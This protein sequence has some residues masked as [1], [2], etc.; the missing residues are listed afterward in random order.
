[1]FQ[2]FT[3]ALPDTT[4]SGDAAA[5]AQRVLAAIR[6]GH[7]YSTIDGLGGATAMSFT[8]V[9]GTVT[10]V[11]GDALPLDGP[12][13]LRVDVQGPDT[14][15]IDVLKDGRLLQTSTGTEL[16]LVVDATAAVYRVEVALPGSPGDPPVP[17]VVSNPIYVGREA[18]ATVLS[19][20]HADASGFAVQY[21]DGPASDWTIE[22]SPASLGALDVVPA[23]GGRQLSLRYGLGGTSAAGPFVAFVMPAGSAVGAHDRLMFTARANRPMRL[24]VQLRQPEGEAGERWH[25]SVYLDSSP[26]AIT[27]YFDD[28]RASGATSNSLPVL[29][30]VEAILFVVDTVNTPLGASGTLWIDDVQYGR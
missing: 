3:N 4:L 25:R 9:S 8:A 1:M 27:V 22:T 2:V 21:A 28:L 26:R 10:A 29:E 23:E 6:D 24:S 5:D 12:V 14:T 30:D 19:D 15:R 18:A 20:P 16:E 17:W 11:A 7:V 13:T